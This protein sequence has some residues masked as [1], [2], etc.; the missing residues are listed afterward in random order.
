MNWR[1]IQCL[2]EGWPLD[3]TVYDAAASSSLVPLSIESMSRRSAPVA[4]PQP[5]PTLGLARALRRTADDIELLRGGMPGRK[6]EMT[7]ATNRSSPIRSHVISL[8]RIPQGAAGNSVFFVFPGGIHDPLR[9]NGCPQRGKP[10][11]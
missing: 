7:G 9:T 3:L 11:P 10:F 5:E 6:N 1:L 8:T 4:A 2:L